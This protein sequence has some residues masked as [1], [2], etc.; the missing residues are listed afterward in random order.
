MVSCQPG[1]TSM[2]FQ[3]VPPGGQMPPAEVRA[4]PADPAAASSAT[5]AQSADTTAAVADGV[6]Q[7]AT[8]VIASAPRAM[9][10][11]PLRKMSK[12]QTQGVD[13]SKDGYAANSDPSTLP[14]SEG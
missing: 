5:G 12:L 13:I 3:R 14:P 2:L 7:P 6:D 9:K 10:F 11:D 4:D 8:T 1:C